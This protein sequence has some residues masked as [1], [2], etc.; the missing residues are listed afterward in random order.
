[1]LAGLLRDE[2][3]AIYAYGVLGARLPDAERRLA[4]TAFDAHRAARDR[5]RTRLLALGASP[6]A[7][8][9]AYDVTVAGRAQ[10][11]ALAV[12]LEEGL[13]VR[14]RDLVALGTEKQDRA[15]GVQQLQDC[16]VRAA[17][18]RGM[19]GLTPTVALPGT[20]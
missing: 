16:A 19:S 20:G 5:L 13:G 15:L 1:V 8:K 7:P 17:R 14:W 4:R 11:L 18:W 6:A 9:P 10:A 12:R 2:H 3:A